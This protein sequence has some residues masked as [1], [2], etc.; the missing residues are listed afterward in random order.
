M[1]LF[2][3]LNSMR[4]IPTEALTKKL[5]D[6]NPHWKAGAIDSAVKN[7]RKRG[8]FE[9][10]FPL[11]HQSGVHRAVIL[12]GPRRAGKT[13][14]L[15]QTIQTLIEHRVPAKN[16][17][18]LSLDVPLFQG[19]SLEELVDLY[20]KLHGKDSI[21]GCFVFFDEIQY[22][23]NWG[24]HL[25][26]LVDRDKKTRFVASGSAAATLNRQ[27]KESGAGRFTDFLLPPLTF[28]EYLDLLE[29]TDKL[30]KENSD[31]AVISVEAKKICC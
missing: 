25:K 9:L 16:V 13:V 4:E 2:D 30:I 19:L 18:Y 22:H 6:L 8:Y 28:Y 15:Q 26:V 31:S 12:M 23:A 10:F 20:S 5:T 11:V 14:I 24:Q 29:L 27:S 3:T 7:F 21:E 1:T 17:L